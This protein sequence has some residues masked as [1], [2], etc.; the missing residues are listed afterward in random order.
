MFLQI[1]T[2]H[3]LPSQRNARTLHPAFRC[4]VNASLEPE[5][6][7]ALCHN[8]SNQIFCGWFQSPRNMLSTLSYYNVKQYR[9]HHGYHGWTCLDR[10]KSNQGWSKRPCRHLDFSCARWRSF[11]DPLHLADRQPSCLQIW[12]RSPLH[13]G[14]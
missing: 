9:D 11:E 10:Y 8:C 2:L 5:W 13:V 4:N 12:I 6:I 7:V 14:S 3:H 1:C